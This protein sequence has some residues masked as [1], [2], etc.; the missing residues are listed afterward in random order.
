MQ[1]P[2]Q[3][4]GTGSRCRSV[5]DSPACAICDRRI[6][7]AP[8]ILPGSSGPVCLDRG[9]RCPR[10]ERSAQTPLRPGVRVRGPHRARRADPARHQQGA[11]GPGRRGA[12]RS[13]SSIE[14]RGELYFPYVVSERAGR[15]RPAG[16]T[17]PSRR[18]WHRR[19]G[20]ADRAIRSAS[21][22]SA[23]DPRFY[24][25][26]DRQTGGS[27]R[28]VLAA[29]LVARQGAIGVLQVVNRHGGAFDDDDLD[30]PRGARRQPSPSRSRTRS[31]TSS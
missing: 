12:L 28:S 18:P 30:V 3:A 17:A 5:A 10:R 21:T 27:T 24:P 14:A 31:C 29:P 2:C 1:T 4:T 8:P 26:I 23:A 9:G 19:R 6:G 11:R 15:R 20:P 7:S 25:G 22:T 13:F 16:R